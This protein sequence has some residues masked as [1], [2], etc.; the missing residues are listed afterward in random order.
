MNRAG[1]APSA[2]TLP[3]L[4]LAYLS[5]VG[6]HPVEQIEAA[7]DA[8]FATVGLRLVAPRGLALLHDIVSDIVLQRGIE[9][10][11][12]ATGVEIYDVDAI[13]LA[14][15]TDVPALARTVE[16]AAQL[17]ASV[18]Q[19]V[20]EDPDLARAQARF[21]LLC[22]MARVRQLAIAVEYMRWR[23]LR[24]L[25]QAA[26]FVAGASQPNA[27][28]CLDCLHVSR[29]GDT[30]ADVAALPAGAVGYVQLCDAS[31]QMPTTTDQLL[32]EARNG[33]LFPGDGTLPLQ[34]LLDALPADVP[35][36]LEVPR[37]IDVDRSVRERAGQAFA[38]MQRFFAQRAARK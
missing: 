3:P 19:V 16:V 35:L 24:S 18:V 34:D 15:D 22:E 13:T 10:A 11:L 7:A 37:A 28:L 9:R 4:G 1:T 29:C 31:A 30:T 33:R 26:A 38:A 12:Q 21:A 36:S 14:A 5:V 32:A 6:A 2:A 8:G 25:A 27:F 17:G 23:S 20:V